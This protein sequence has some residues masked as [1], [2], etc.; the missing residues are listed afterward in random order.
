MRPQRPGAATPRHFEAGGERAAERLRRS[1]IFS[2][3]VFRNS[4]RDRIRCD[5]SNLPAE[6]RQSCFAQS[7][8]FLHREARGISRSPAVFDGPGYWPPS[9]PKRPMRNSIMSFAETPGGRALPAELDGDRVRHF[10]PDLAGDQHADHF[11]RADAEHVGRRIAPP[12]GEMAVA[13]RP[14]TWP[15]PEVPA[16]GQH[17]CGRCPAAS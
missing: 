8:A 10:Q 16:L 6:A 9:M 5:E 11:R 14:R 12:V 13:R 15:R 1:P 7:H 2:I 17:D 4:R 3:S